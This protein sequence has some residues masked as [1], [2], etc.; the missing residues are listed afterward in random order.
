MRRTTRLLVT[1]VACCAAILLG[2]CDGDGDGGSAPAARLRPHSSWLPVPIR[3]G[4][5]R[6]SVVALR[7][8]VE[9]RGLPGESRCA[10][11]VPRERSHGRP[12][13][14]NRG[15]CRTHPLSMC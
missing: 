3:R 6:R 5:W 10:R 8:R 13:V 15:P 14:G 1:S 9:M 12:R 4:G 11:P 2:V 7:H